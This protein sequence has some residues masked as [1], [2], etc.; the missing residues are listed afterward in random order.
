MNILLSLASMTSL[1]TGILIL[2]VPRL[3]NYVVATDLIVVG[4][5]GLFAAG[6]PHV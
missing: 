6:G 3:L 5:I 2:P 4:L 1:I